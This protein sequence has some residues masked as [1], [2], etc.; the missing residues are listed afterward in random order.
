MTDE[1]DST[2]PRRPPTIDLK[3][4]EVGEPASPDGSP[5][6]QSDAPNPNRPRS[7]I[8][9]AVGGGAVGALVVIAVGAGL[10]AAGYGPSQ[11]PP[12][13]QSIGRRN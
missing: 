13:H 3:A 12:D 10:W 1:P 11:Q 9:T 2:P 6:Q 8:K 7:W 5:E 4:T